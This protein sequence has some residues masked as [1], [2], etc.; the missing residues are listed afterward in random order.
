MIMLIEKEVIGPGK[1]WYID[2]QTGEARVWDVKPETVKQLH[3]DGTDMIA[4]GLAIPVPFEHDFEAH[5]MTPKQKLLNNAGEV[6]G[7]AIK[8][9]KDER[10]G[11]LRKGVLFSSVDIQDDDAKKKIGKSVRWTSPWI[12]SFVDGNGRK[13]E[14]VI[15]HLALTTRPR[16]VEQNSFPSIAAALSVGALHTPGKDGFCVSNAA[17]LVVRKKDK[18]LHPR[19]PMA[20]SM[21]SGV[22]LAESPIDE[23]DDDG[24]ELPLDDEPDSPD[25]DGLM[26][27]L[28]DNTGDVKMEELLCDLLSALGV[29]MPENVSEAEFKRALYEATMNKVKELTS[30]GQ[31]PTPNEPTKSPSGDNPLTGQIQQEQQPMYMSLEEINT[32]PDATMKKIALSMYNENV[33]LRTEIAAGKKATEALNAVKLKE[34]DGKRRYRVMTLSKVIP[35]AKADLEAMLALPSMALSLGEGGVVIDPMA[36]TLSL[37]EKSVDRIP[38][39]LRTDMAALSV[40]AQPTDENALTDERISELADDLTRRMG[41]QPATK[42]S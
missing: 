27:P 26:N 33:K 31:T 11:K 34:E 15:G 1:Y 25:M 18:T 29:Q 24:E 22:P 13:W 36:Q 32:I 41:Y 39:L 9:V 10:T 4:A 12:T 28:Q 35:T 8:D 23:L 30:K 6:K 7:Y 3:K 42:A 38:T 17:R 20:F 5:P 21:Y 16:V 19:F 2:Q 37:L 14:N 40:A